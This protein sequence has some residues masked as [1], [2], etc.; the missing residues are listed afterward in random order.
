MRT[1]YVVSLVQ[2]L[3]V[4]LFSEFLHIFPSPG[5]LSEEIFLMMTGQGTG[6]WLWQN[7]IMNHFINS[8]FFKTSHVW[9]HSRSLGYLVSGSRLCKYGQ[10]WVFSYEVDLKSNQ[11]LV[12]YSYRFCATVD[13]EYFVS[14]TDDNAKKFFSW[15]GI[16]FSLLAAYRVPYWTNKTIT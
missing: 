6:L 8:F 11:T 12:R 13:L 2:C 14:R 9:D 15:V 5:L 3:T 7:I 4:C 1:S 16:C 10:V